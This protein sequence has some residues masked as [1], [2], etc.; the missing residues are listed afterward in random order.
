MARAYLK[1]HQSDD[2]ALKESY[3]KALKESLKYCTKFIKKDKEMEFVPDQ[4]D[5]I[6]ELR[7]DHC[8]SGHGNGR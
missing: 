1:I 3:P 7:R 4:L 2:P 5:F 6:E 8:T